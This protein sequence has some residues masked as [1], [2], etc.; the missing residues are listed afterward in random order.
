MTSSAE[1]E[2]ASRSG[3]AVTRAVVAVSLFVIVASAGLVLT[4]GHGRDQ[5]I[6]SLVA[7]EML[8]G[9]MP[10]RDAFDFKP[11]G[12]FLVYALARALFGGAQ[13]GIRILE[14]ASMG[15]TCFGLVR[16]S[17]MLFGKRTVGFMAGALAS[18]VHAH[19][20]FWHTAQPETF[21]GSLTVWAI[22]LAFR[23]DRSEKSRAFLLQWVGSGVLFGMAGLMKPPLAFGGA[24]IAGLAAVRTVL[25]ARSEKKRSNTGGNWVSMSVSWKCSSSDPGSRICT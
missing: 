22:L 6:Y 18:Q 3:D 9:R 1:K 5:S 15:L 10:Y 8:A 19:L 16:L 7:R 25:A 23:A 21:G 14:V 11:P 20:D 17:E 2:P 13:I 4:F 24:A 12:I